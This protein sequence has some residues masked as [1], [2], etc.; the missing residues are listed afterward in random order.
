MRFGDFG[1]ISFV[2]VNFFCLEGNFGFSISFC[3]NWYIK[4]YE[5]WGG[6]LS[7]VKFIEEVEGV[8]E[9]IV[10]VFCMF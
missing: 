4:C 3:G 8:F 7:V 9:C 10:D 2:G 1:W 5:V 6:G